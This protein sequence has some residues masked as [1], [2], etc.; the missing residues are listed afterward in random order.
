DLEIGDAVRPEAI[1]DTAQDLALFVAAIAMGRGRAGLAA[2][3]G[4][5]EGDIVARPEGVGLGPAH[6]DAAAAVAG[7]EA[8]GGDVL[9]LGALQP[10]QVRR[11][12]GAFHDEGW[13]KH[14]DI[15]VPVGDADVSDRHLVEQRIALAARTDRRRRTGRGRRRAWRAGDGGGR[16][17]TGIE[18][19]IAAAGVQA[20]F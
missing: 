15:E 13:L 3:K 9:D 7:A 6:F 14:A 12:G 10:G 18:A 5:V 1:D 19:A 8:V 17:A 4:D 2:G 11:R 20:Y 16:G